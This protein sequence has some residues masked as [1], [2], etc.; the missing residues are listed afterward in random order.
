[1]K[2]FINYF[3]GIL[4]Q[5]IKK[6]EK[7]Y[8]IKSNN[9]N[10]IFKPIY[11]NIYEFYNT[12]SII[13][14]LKIPSLEII[15]NIKGDIIT[16]Y[17]DYNY[18]LLKESYIYESE[19]NLEKIFDYDITIYINKLK[20]WKKMWQDKIDY[21]EY[22]INQFGYK[23]KIICNSINYYFKLGECAIELLNY[24]NQEYFKICICHR[25]LS[26]KRNIEFYDP[27]NL[28]LDNITR[29]IADY[30]KIK[31]F[32]DEISE[33]E[34]LKEIDKI[35][36]DKNEVLLFLSRLIYPTYNFDIYDKIINEEVSE[37]KIET[38]IKKNNSFELF[39]KAI[40]N[41]LKSKYILPEIEWLNS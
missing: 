34:I 8:F 30:I 40:Y 5:N 20:D 14:D 31:Y 41:H 24:I 27:T 36:F 17:E 15:R 32:F 28:T 1:M 23:Y 25:R 6:N 37:E 16:V 4:V 13:E 18:V 12:Y 2:N 33:I 19:L 35:Y 26:L 38:I 39:L 22:Q 29:D 3:Y 21:Y 11:Y 9:Y 7:T 10:Y